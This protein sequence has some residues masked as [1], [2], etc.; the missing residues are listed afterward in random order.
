[1][2]GSPVSRFSLGGK[3]QRRLDATPSPPQ[4]GRDSPALLR[5]A[6]PG[7]P[8]LPA[9]PAPLSATS[10]DLAGKA[11]SCSSDAHC[12]LRSETQRLSQRRISL[13]CSTIL[14]QAG[15]KHLSQ[16]AARRGGPEGHGSLG[17]SCN[18]DQNSQ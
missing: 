3:S 5:P 7:T 15:G 16:T 11:L 10:T 6:P 8:M 17:C 2:E 12:T 13:F 18:Q 9:A 1:M 4:R 14:Q